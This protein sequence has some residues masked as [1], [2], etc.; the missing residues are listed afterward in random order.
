MQF[1][2]WLLKICLFQNE[3]GLYDTAASILSIGEHV[4]KCYT[5]QTFYSG[6]YYV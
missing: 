2:A 6:K 5:K 4:M 3:F 1:I